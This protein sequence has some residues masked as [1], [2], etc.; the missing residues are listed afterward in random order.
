MH[1]GGAMFSQKQRTAEQ[2]KGK[3]DTWQRRVPYCR[4][5]C[6]PK[7]WQIELCLHVDDADA[8]EDKPHDSILEFFRDF[9]RLSGKLTQS[10]GQV[11]DN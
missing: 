3:G 8:N 4:K 9:K 1:L 10:R 11:V 6:P 7:R 2:G 5:F